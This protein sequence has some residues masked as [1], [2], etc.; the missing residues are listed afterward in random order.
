[1]SIEQAP[2]PVRELSYLE[3]ARMSSD[4]REI[5]PLIT[6][7]VRKDAPRPRVINGRFLAEYEQMGAE[8]YAVGEAIFPDVPDQDIPELFKPPSYRKTISYDLMQPVNGI[9]RSLAEEAL[10]ELRHFSVNKIAD[11]MLPVL[12]T[13]EIPEGLLDTPP[14][15]RQRGFQTCT[16]ACFRMVH[17]ALA[18]STPP[19]DIMQLAW[20][21]AT[22][23]AL[24][25]DEMQWSLFLT[26]EF[27]RRTGMLVSSL[28]MN[29]TDFGTI[30]KVSQ[31]IRQRQPHARV[32]CAVNVRTETATDPLVWHTVIITEVGD[33][34]V[35]AQ[36]P[37]K[38]FQSAGGEGRRYDKEEFIRMWATGMNRAHMTIAVP[39]EWYTDS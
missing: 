29:A 37:S 23:E 27:K 5:A 16:M 39:Q 4:Y 13:Q 6:E 15:E 20:R 34:Y 26:R 33:D 12:K 11:R 1:M 36:N 31:K 2:A 28:T 25:D 18:G 9:D 22:G 8:L 7:A 3:E 32:Y 21:D 30:G 38:V 35:V 24:L 10:R 14:Y 19:E 17:S